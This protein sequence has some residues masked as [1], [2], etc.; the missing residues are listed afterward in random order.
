MCSLHVSFINYSFGKIV[1][2]LTHTTAND[3][4]TEKFNR[5][6]TDIRGRG[7]SRFLVCVCVFFLLF[8]AESSGWMRRNGEIDCDQECAW[9]SREISANRIY[10]LPVCHSLGDWEL[11]TLMFLAATFFYSLLRV[12]SFNSYVGED[13]TIRTDNVSDFFFVSG[14]GCLCRSRFSYLDACV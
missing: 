6:S 13:G 4:A 5:Y 9:H 8:G 12:H 10:S 3:R 1:G 14:G 11:Y 2:T 7:L